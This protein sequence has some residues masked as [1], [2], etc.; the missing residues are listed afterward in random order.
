[1]DENQSICSKLQDLGSILGSNLGLILG[2]ILSLIL[3]LSPKVA[4]GSD[5]SYIHG[6]F[7]SQFIFL[8]A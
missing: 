6:K 3:G 1:M 8:P 4:D 2:S 5:L 7:F